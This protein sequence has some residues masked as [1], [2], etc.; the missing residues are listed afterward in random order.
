[1]STQY[2][3]HFIKSKK[4]KLLV[5]VISEKL[6]INHRT[7]FDGKDSM[8]IVSTNFGEIYLIKGSP[9]IVKTKEKLFPTLISV[10]VLSLLPRVTVDMGAVPKVCNGANIMAP[11]IIRY[12]GEFM[13]GD[14]VLISDEKHG[15]TVAVGQAM[16][17]MSE[18]KGIEEGV[19]VQNLHYVGDKIWTFIKKMEKRQKQ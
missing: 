6:K 13:K 5:R 2:K 16:Y 3:R 8:E 1:M 4:V 12:D 10:K 19:I 7:I 14:L 9:L 11:G 15:K 17:N 18:A